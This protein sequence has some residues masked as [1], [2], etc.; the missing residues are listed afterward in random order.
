MCIRDRFN[1][2]RE[3]T[4]ASREPVARRYSYLESKETLKV[5]EEVHVPKRVVVEEGEAEEEK[6]NNFCGSIQVDK[7]TSVNTE[8]QDSERTSQLNPCLLYTSRCV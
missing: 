4:S 8:L 5:P 7:K 3:Q 6:R 1:Y 2:V